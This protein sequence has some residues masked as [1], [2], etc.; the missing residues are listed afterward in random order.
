MVIKDGVLFLQG[1]C[2]YAL[3]TQFAEQILR[4]G[5]REQGLVG[6]VEHARAGWLRM[7]VCVY[8]L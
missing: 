6:T 1:V 8:R 3:V 7:G 4:H 2:K 5:L